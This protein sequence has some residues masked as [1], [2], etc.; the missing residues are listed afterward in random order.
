MHSQ[1]VLFRGLAGL[2]LDDLVVE[3][4]KV[5]AHSRSE[6]PETALM[7]GMPPAGIV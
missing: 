1:Q 2:D 6:E 3:R 4:E 5:L 7:F